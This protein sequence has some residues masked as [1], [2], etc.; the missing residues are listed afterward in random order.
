MRIAMMIEGQ[1]GVT[2]PE[3]VAMAGACER[4]GL[5][6]LFRSDHYAGLLGDEARDATDA[7]AVISAL[8]AVTE[9]IR[10]GTLVSPVTFRHPSQLAKV[11]ATADQV[12][13]GRIELGI[14]AGWNER[15]HAAY[16]FPFPPLGTRFEMLEEQLEIVRRL[17]TEEV[18]TFEGRHYHLNAARPLPRPVQAPPTLLV[19]G[20]ANRRSAALAARFADEYNTLGATLDEVAARRDRLSAA[21]EK[22]G[23][24]PATLPLSLMTGCIVGSSADDVMGRT[25]A[26]LE[27][28]GETGDPAAFLAARRDRWIVG[29]VGE[30]RERLGDLATAG[31]SRV[32][33]QHFAHRDVDMVEVIAEQLV[34]RS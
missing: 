7:W 12:S 22:I 1:E 15:E 29:T 2:W 30:V 23:R 13:G 21:C 34:D 16:G 31:V 17:W 4:G 9:R 33:L 8:A 26:V 6:A 14:G 19:G 32:M 20:V 3:W 11:T 5:D 18:V 25:R 28:I 10:L 24:D 27:R